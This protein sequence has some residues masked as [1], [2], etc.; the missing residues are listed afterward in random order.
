MTP[1]EL[2]IKIN[3]Y[4]KRLGFIS[5]LAFRKESLEDILAVLEQIDKTCIQEERKNV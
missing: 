3:Y 5:T 2:L 4:C 1:D